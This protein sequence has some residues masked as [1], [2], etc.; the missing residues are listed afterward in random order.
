M[1]EIDHTNL[2]TSSQIDTVTFD[3]RRYD[4]FFG[5]KFHERLAELMRVEMSDAALS[6]VRHGHFEAFLAYRSGKFEQDYFR[7]EKAENKKLE[8]VAT[9]AERLMNSLIELVEFGQSAKKL[10][11]EILHNP[12]HYTSSSGVKL[13]HILDQDRYSDQLFSLRQLLSDLCVSAKRASNHK[14]VDMSVAL[15]K[16]IRQDGSPDL[17]S[18]QALM[19]KKNYRDEGTYDQQVME[20]K[21]RSQAHKLAKNHALLSF[22][23]E[24]RTLWLS[25]STSAFTHG[26]NY[27]GKT[28]Y[29]SRSLDAIELSFA[30][31][32][33][34]VTRQSIVTAIRT[35]N[36]ELKA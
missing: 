14:P 13:T 3:G 16:T 34:E 35:V 22:V 9:D 33:P 30:Q 4:D 17:E 27:G 1:T 28:Q 6:A 24:F 7:S 19:R 36:S 29:V 5:V 32:A 20:W 10:E 23:R 25:L 2:N 26:H 12:T 21:K 31:H 15:G 18:L 11:A 8:R